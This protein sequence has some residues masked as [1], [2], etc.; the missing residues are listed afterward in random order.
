MSKTENTLIK[1]S[2]YILLWIIIF[3][4]LMQ[5][6][7]LILKKWNYTVLLGN[8]LSAVTAAVN[9]YLMGL[10]LEKVVECDEKSARYK[11]KLSHT[12][13]TLMLFAVAAVG[14]ATTCFNL[15]AVLIPL[16]FP[17]LAIAL[18]LLIKEK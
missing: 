2:K 12:L 4:I 8:L 10:T 3:S 16:F 18:R 1:E 5:A 11:V 15:A 14:A 6:V 17:R 7:F 13:R 9:F